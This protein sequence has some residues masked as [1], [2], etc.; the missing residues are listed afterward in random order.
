MHRLKTV[1]PNARIWWLTLTPEV[2]PP[3]AD[4][5]LP[6]TAQ[7]LTALQATHFDILFNLDKDREACALAAMLSATVKKGFTFVQGKPALPTRM[8]H[9]N[10]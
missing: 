8:P 4:V 10:S 7:S 6:F 5:V 2:V 3:P 9:I 1:Y